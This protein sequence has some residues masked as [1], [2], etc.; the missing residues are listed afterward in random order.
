MVS[1]ILDAAASAEPVCDYLATET[2][3]LSIAGR[4]CGAL[5]DGSLVLVAGDPPIDPLS[6]SDALRAA[7][8]LHRAVIGVPGG[9][10]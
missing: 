9:P 6:L 7:A 8:Q 3:Y 2:H 10:A 5:R 4:I 1:A